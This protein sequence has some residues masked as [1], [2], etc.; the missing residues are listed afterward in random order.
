MS[1]GESHVLSDGILD[2]ICEALSLDR[3]GLSFEPIT[4]GHFNDSFVITEDG[5]R[6]LV[7]RIAPPD[8]AGFLFYERLM[9]R[10]EPIIAERILAETPVPVPRVLFSDFS[11]KAA[12]R[13]YLVMEKLRGRALSE[14]GHRLTSAQTAN[15]LRRVGECLQQTHTLEG[16]AYGYVGPH[17]PME[18]CPRWDEAFEK[19]WALIIDDIIGCGAYPASWREPLGGL[20]SRHRGLFDYQ[21]PPVLLH[22]DVWSQ[23]VLVDEDGNLTGLLDWDRALYG[24]PEIEFSVLDYCGI[25]RPAFWKG[26]G[27]P[28]QKTRHFLFRQTFYLLYEHQKYIVINRLRRKD[29]QRA[30]GYAAECKGMLNSLAEML[31]DSQLVTALADGFD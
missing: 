31:H 7:L 8:D 20:A 1:F 3:D 15:A 5:G 29:F 13:D 6:S 23:N 14:M 4:T 11:R 30:A 27:T 22:M 19:M 16:T 24:D 12:D 2:R 10:Q 9:M 21:G 25:S 28:P 18:P 26:Y 17:K